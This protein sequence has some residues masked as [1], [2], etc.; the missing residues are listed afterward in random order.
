[1]DEWDLV[2]QAG[3]IM[4]QL[5]EW[6]EKQGD[7]REVFGEDIAEAIEDFMVSGEFWDEADE[8]DDDE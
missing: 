5:I 2:E 8:E 7:W 3:E 6:A 1:M 4:E